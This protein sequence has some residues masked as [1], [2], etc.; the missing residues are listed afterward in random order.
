MIHLIQHPSY[1]KITPDTIQPQ[2]PY[3]SDYLSQGEELG[4]QVVVYTDEIQGAAA[5]FELEFD[6]KYQVYME[7][8]VDINRPFHKNDPK[9]DQSSDCPD[10]LPDCLIP[11]TP[12]DVFFINCNYI[13]LWVSIETENIGETKSVLKISRALKMQFMLTILI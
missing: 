11:I 4:Y 2:N 12:D 8:Y 13:V 6:G 7:K 1:T 5:K 9:M 10:I 3:T